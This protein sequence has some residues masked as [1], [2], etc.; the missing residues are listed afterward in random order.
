MRRF[1]IPLC[2]FVFV[3]TVAHAQTQ[4]AQE[5]APAR[6]P[7][8][9][10]TES[11][12]SIVIPPLPNAP[13]TLTLQ[14]EWMRRFVDAGTFTVVNE[15]RIARD[16]RGRIYQERAV[17]GPKN[18][19]VQSHTSFIQIADPAKHTLYT[20][21]MLNPEH[22]CYL[23]TYS[24]ST[25]APPRIARETKTLNLP[26]DQGIESDVALGEGSTEGI[27]TIG[28]RITETYNPGVMGNDS[29]FTVEREYWYSPKLGIDLIS[30]ISD[31][32]LG[33]QTFTATNIQA[34]EPDP[35]LF[36][37]PQGFTVV[38][39]RGHTPAARTALPPST[40]RSYAPSN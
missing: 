17:L 31:P 30:K 27:E 13:F 40:P 8:G 22:L 28:T 3:A 12:Q 21:S 19:K 1:R 35:S 36:E 20:C 25:V 5:Q 26:D 2:V 29:Q 7:D 16:R 15:R 23:S 18:S 38:D 9:G 34:A 6:E 11:L 33:I 14:T 39:E 32:R 10:V 37:L 24:G 4:S